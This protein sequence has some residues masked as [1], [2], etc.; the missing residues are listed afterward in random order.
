MIARSGGPS[1]QEGSDCFGSSATELG[2]PGR[3]A[4]AL[5]ASGVPRLK[6]A[7]TALNGPYSRPPYQDGLTWQAVRAIRR[8]VDTV[9]K[10]H[11]RHETMTI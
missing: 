6:C 4:A 8:I 7:L 3:T 10:R 1:F 2:T 5:A 9:I 11:R